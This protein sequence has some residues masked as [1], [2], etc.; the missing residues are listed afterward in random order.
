M[1]NFVYNMKQSFNLSASFT[2]QSSKQRS[3]NVQAYNG[4]VVNCTLLR[5]GLSMFSLFSWCSVACGVGHSLV[6]VD[7]KKNFDKIEQVL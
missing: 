2:F 6:I 3:R 7:R 1:G 4:Q 5:K